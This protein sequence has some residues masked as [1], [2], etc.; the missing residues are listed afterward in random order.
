[1]QWQT[2]KQRDPVKLPIKIQVDAVA[3]QKLW[4]WTDQAK[5]EVSALGLV[6][7]L[8]DAESGVLNGLLVTDFLLTK[9]VCSMDETTMDPAGVAELLMDLES[10]DVDTKKL[11][12]WAHSHGGM[13]VFWSGQDDQCIEG[14]ANGEWL[15]SL[16]VNKRRDSIMRLDQYHP[17]HL[18]MSDCV[19]EVHYRT[20]DGLAEA[21][22]AEFKSQVT[23]ASGLL[24]PNLRS[25]FDHIA[26]L[27]S[28]HERGSLTDEDLQ[29][30]MSWCGLSM[31]DFDEVP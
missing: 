7:E 10:R 6:D 18:Y 3:M 29:E 2:N 25:G 24:M 21:C 22:F 20:A 11:R 4:L 8:R 31:E 17:A 19:W 1:M 30:E 27:K 15:L 23:E 28:A 14:L 12:C 26:D 16:V 5:G 13:S 9:Q